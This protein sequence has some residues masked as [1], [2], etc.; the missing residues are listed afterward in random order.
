[1]GDL[2][3]TNLTSNGGPIDLKCLV[4]LLYLNRMKKI[5]SSETCYRFFFTFFK[6]VN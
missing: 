3:L 6:K 4:T 2:G 5:E 1:M